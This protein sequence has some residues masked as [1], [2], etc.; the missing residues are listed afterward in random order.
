VGNGSKQAFGQG[1]FPSGADLNTNRA[2]PG[3][4]RTAANFAHGAAA[5]TDRAAHTHHD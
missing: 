3:E 2:T 4:H 1:A 5:Y